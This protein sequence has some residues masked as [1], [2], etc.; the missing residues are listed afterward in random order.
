MFDL[1][2]VDVYFVPA[3]KHPM[4]AILGS[5]SQNEP[6]V[7]ILIKLAVDFREETG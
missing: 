6:T 7:A 5:G 4:M 1:R 3:T 2:P